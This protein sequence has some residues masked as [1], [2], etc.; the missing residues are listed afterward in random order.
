M[1]QTLPNLRKL[2][3]SY[4]WELEKI[5]DFGEFP[6]LEWLNLRGCDKLVELGPSIGLLKKLVYLNLYRCINLVSIPNN[7]FDLSSLEYLNMQRCS[8]AFKNGSTSSVFKYLLPSLHSLDCLC[9]VDISFCNLSQVPDSIE[10]LLS[11]EKLNLRG[12]NFV[13]LPSL[14]KL[15]KL[16]CLN[17]EHCKLLESLPQLPSPT[18]MRERDEFE[19]YDISYNMLE[20][21]WIR[22]VIFN[23]PKLGERECCYSMAFSWMKQFIMANPQS[24][25]DIQIVIPGSE[26]PSWINNQ[27][28]GDSIQ[29]DK[30]PI[31]HDNNIVGILCCV[32]FTMAPYQGDSWM[33]LRLKSDYN[34]R[35]MSFPV[36]L[37]EDLVTTKS[38]H[39]W[40]IYFPRE[41]CHEFGKI[42]FEC[43][44]ME[45]KSCGY[46]WVCKQDLQEFNLTIMNHEAS[47][48]QK[49][50]IL[51]IEDGT[52][53]QSQSVQESFISQGTETEV[54]VE[55]PHS[56]VADEVSTESPQKKIS[57]LHTI[58]R[59]IGRFLN[60]CCQQGST[61]TD[62]DT[63]PD[64]T[65]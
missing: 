16:V 17:L 50:K 53:P 48:P 13:T 29:I 54:S 6:N 1:S 23:C 49:C 38:S 43:F 15:S 57:N 20:F 37:D 44:G 28:M 56:H 9:I 7:I 31:M 11:L 18:T 42:S 3:L 36:I 34:V 63:T 60:N 52:Q 19:W 45:V 32:L 64:T 27:S 40:I 65:L 41:S 22:L 14:R 2:D 26:I 4:S 47:L 25:K 33:R 8:K 59:F 61:D 21:D 46:R 10:C 12:N 39:L 62:T 30:S 51:E 58:G 55:V 5:I 35:E 24:F